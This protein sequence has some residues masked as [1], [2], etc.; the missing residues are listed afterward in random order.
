[1][2]YDPLNGS[3]SLGEDAYNE[4]SKISNYAVRDTDR[5][6][7]DSELMVECI[8]FVALHGGGANRVA[9]VVVG[10]LIDGD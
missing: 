4:A 7:Q 10:V 8:R 6:D 9:D 1:M 5:G 3:I 2:G